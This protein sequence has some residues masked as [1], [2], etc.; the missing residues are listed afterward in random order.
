MGRTGLASLLVSTASLPTFEAST[1][2]GL[3][4]TPAGHA[5]LEKE[6]LPVWLP[7][8]RWFGGKARAIGSCAVAASVVSPD[9]SRLLLAEVRYAD[10]VAETYLTPLKLRPPGQPDSEPLAR[11]GALELHDALTDPGFRLALLNL[12]ADEAFWASAGLAV[13]GIAG[14]FLPGLLGD[15]ATVTSRLLTVEQSNSSII[16]NDRVFLKLYR[17]LEHGVNPDAE[18]LQFLGERDVQVPPFAGAVEGHANGATRVLALATGMVPNHGDAWAF[19]LREVNRL[20]KREQAGDGETSRQIEAAYLVRAGQL[21]TRTGQLHC[22]LAA[23]E[24]DPNFASE[25]LTGDDLREL[26]DTIRKSAA[27]LRDLFAQGSRA[28]SPWVPSLAARL[29]PEVLEARLASLQDLHPAARKTR[30]HGDYHLGQVLDTGEDFFIL[31]FEGEPARTL[32]QRRAKRSPFRDVAGML[33]SFHYAAH[34]ALD[35]FGEDRIKLEPRA[36][37]W[38]AR[39]RAAFL[40]SWQAATQGA[41]FRDPDPANERALLDAFLLEKALYEVLYEINNRPAWLGIPARGV[42][43]LFQTR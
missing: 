23:G 27:T 26:A 37:Q 10:G 38:H 8:R 9:G 40:E 24:D 12:I 5:F 34:S 25:P 21:G 28:D 16:Y 17:K 1:A 2:E 30:A 22:A 29:Q 31:D 18:I 36:E 11:V 13:R 43:E 20:L 4:E 7:G 3:F 6:V 33:R 19:T 39:A 42:L 15:R 14:R 32:E 35:T 41:V